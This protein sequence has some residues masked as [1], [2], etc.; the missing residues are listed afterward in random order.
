M[1]GGNPAPSWGRLRVRSPPRSRF[2]LVRNARPTSERDERKSDFFEAAILPILLAGFD[3]FWDHW[4]RQ[5]PSGVGRTA[6]AYVGDLASG[7]LTCAAMHQCLTPAA[8]FNKSSMGEIFRTTS[9]QP[10]GINIRNFAA[11]AHRHW[12]YKPRLPAVGSV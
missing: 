11:Q 7:G 1:S 12:Y 8:P 3:S 4:G 5:T 10:P 2:G 6:G 9:F